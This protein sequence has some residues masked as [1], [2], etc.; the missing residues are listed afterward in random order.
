M[1]SSL[2]VPDSLAKVS[3]YGTYAFL[4]TT[5]TITFIEAL[6]TNVDAV[7][8]IMNLETCISIVAAYFYSKFVKEL[9][10][11]EKGGS[12]NE[13]FQSEYTL[14]GEGDGNGDD[15]DTGVRGSIVGGVSL[16][17]NG[18]I[19]PNLYSHLNET[20]YTDWMIT[21]PIMLL[22]LCLAF[23]YNNT[24]AG[25]LSKLGGTPAGVSFILFAVVLLMDW[26]MIASGYLA[27]TK[28]ISKRDGLVFG[29]LFFFA[30]FAL[31]YFG[32]IHGSSGN[33]YFQNM[34][35]FLVFFVLWTAYGVVY[36]LED[37]A[38]KNTI[39]NVLDLFAK[40][41]VG[42]FFWAYFTG[43]FA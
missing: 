21:T 7:R 42:I 6:R 19:S 3:F 36:W 8:H 29:F 16:S 30:M 40:C 39:Y 26:G 22:V 25:G 34:F 20:R 35:L 14:E 11:A 33:A 1:S 10:D 27:E 18:S 43:V 41:F 9:E 24:L 15:K 13:A 23:Q 5:G 28:K 17:K 31:M 12:A 4:V 37:E 38:L 32:F 2:V